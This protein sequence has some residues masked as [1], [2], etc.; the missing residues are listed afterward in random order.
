LA[1]GFFAGNFANGILRSRPTWP[2]IRSLPWS[3]TER[4]MVDAVTVGL[5]L[6]PFVVA[7]IPLGA[8]QA[9]HVALTL[10]AIATC[11]AS[12]LRK[13]ANRQSGA[14][15]EIM[16][17]AF[18]A[19]GVIAVWPLTSALVFAS[20][21]LF[22]VLGATRDRRGRATRFFELQHDASGDPG[23]VGR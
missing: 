21:P 4:V 16:L 13:G 7:L 9:A 12:A 20:T 17:F 18:V 5:P 6:I 23:W 14:A 22:I 19:G 15:G 1:I 11:A 10:P 2:W 3:S 8:M